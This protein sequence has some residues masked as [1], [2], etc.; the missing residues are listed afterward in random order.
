MIFDGRGCGART[1]SDSR[2]STGPRDRAFSTF[3]ASS[4]HRSITAFMRSRGGAAPTRPVTSTT[5]APATAPRRWSSNIRSRTRPSVLRR[6][7]PRR[8]AADHA[9]QSISGRH[10]R[11]LRTMAT[12]SPPAP[13]GEATTGEVPHPISDWADFM[14][15][16]RTQ[17]PLFSFTVAGRKWVWVNDAELAIAILKLPFDKIGVGPLIEGFEQAGGIGNALT[18]NYGPSWRPRRVLLQRPLS[19]RNVRGFGDIFARQVE[20]KLAGWSDGQ[21]IDAQAEMSELTLAILAE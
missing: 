12:I 9:R 2:A 8:F 16:A 5:P 14:A 19:Y 3:S 1:V 20:R 10:R 21:T 6:S 13:L 18:A 11:I 15:F 4:S 7:V 17:G